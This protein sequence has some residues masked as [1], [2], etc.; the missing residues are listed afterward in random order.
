MAIMK[1]LLLGLAFNVWA[2]TLLA[3]SDAQVL[4]QLLTDF[5]ADYTALALPRLDLSY[6]KNLENIASAEA[7]HTQ[8]RCFER[9]RKALADVPTAQLTEAERLALHTVRYEINLNLQRLELEMAWRKGE[10]GLQGTRVYDE[11]MGKAWYAY[12]LKKW[13]DQSL[14]PEAAYQFGLEEIATVQR[15][16]EALERHETQEAS[17][18]TAQPRSVRYLASKEAVLEGYQVLQAQVRPQ[19]AQYFPHLDSVPPVRIA[20]GT[21]ERMAIAPAYYSHQTFYFNFFGELYDTHDMGW[22]YLHEATPGHHYQQGLPVPERPKV[23]NL[24]HYMSYTEG[25]GAYVDQYGHVLGAYTSTGHVRAHLEWNLIRAVRVALDVGLNYHGWTDAEALE[26]WNQHIQ[27][28]PDIAE[29]EI[30][31]MKRWPAQV[32]TYNYGKR[33]L[34][35]LKGDRSSPEDLKAFH[36]QVLRYGDLPLSVLRS[37]LLAAE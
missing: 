20:P 12:F 26:F 3:Q 2:S 19:A 37:Y 23:L 29:R 10:H 6:V 5:E 27:G 30:K 31:R 34:N 24:F 1:H 21:N 4:A 13:I 7:L 25:W 22:T 28:K 14:T 9:Y 17:T 36:Q 16:L 32:L 18:N 33:V 8:Q 35:E 15:E 11:F